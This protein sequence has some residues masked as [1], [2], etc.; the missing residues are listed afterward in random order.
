MSRFIKSKVNIL[1]ILILTIFTLIISAIYIQFD[2]KTE[3]L[4]NQILQNEISKASEYAFNIS[5]M[6][7]SSIK[8]DNLS[9]TL[10]NDKK[11]R[12]EIEDKLRLFK[13]SKYLHIFVVKKDKKG[14]LR[15]LLDAEKDFQERGFFDQKFD[16]QSELWYK[17]FDSS[18]YEYA[19]QDNIEDLWI[20]F[21]YP[22][23]NKGVTEAVLAFDFSSNEHT[24]IINMITPVKNIFLVLSII[25][26]I[27]LIFSYLQLYLNY[28]IENKSMHDPLTSCYNRLFLDSLRSKIDLSKY[29]LCMID[30]D[31][32]KK[33]NDTYG[34]GIGD[35]VL[36]S[37]TKRILNQIKKGDFLIRYGGE[38]FLL[39]IKKTDI[40]TSVSSI[41][42]RIRQIIE[43]SPI[44]VNDN[45]INVTVSI[46]VNNKPQ[47]SVTLNEAIKIADEM[48]YKAK[49]TGRNKV[50]T[51]HEH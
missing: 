7:K 22:I 20:T 9:Q 47:Q 49:N 50:V 45:I 26:L 5:K 11:L 6:I 8:N 25:L 48:L 34:H 23:T 15:Y 42:E 21:L 32:F 46:G 30:I 35:I 1:S 43:N 51:S 40:N 44:A 33:I 14:K 17:V 3:E 29:D 19:I 16:P 13:S 2:T 24:F 41:P 36:K 31:L 37:F 4:K 27:F 18:H 28:K 39:F 38:E 12:K 10:K